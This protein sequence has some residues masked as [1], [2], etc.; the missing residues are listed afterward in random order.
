VVYEPEFE[1][2]DTDDEIVPGG[3]SGVTNS[4]S[5]SN[6]VDVFG[7]EEEDREVSYELGELDEVEI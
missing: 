5:N 4:L 3:V 2:P 1:L 7:D 6:G